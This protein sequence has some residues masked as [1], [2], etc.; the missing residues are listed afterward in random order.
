MADT[1]NQLPID[2]V[3]RPPEQGAVTRSLASIVAAAEA[4]GR[5]FGEA[6]SKG[7]KSGM[8]GSAT[9]GSDSPIVKRV[10]NHVHGAKKAL[11]DASKQIE[12]YYKKF[13]KG[14]DAAIKSLTRPGYNN[15][16]PAWWDKVL[17][18]Q[19]AG[20]KAIEASQ[21]RAEATIGKKAERVVRAATQEGYKNAGPAWWSKVL[22]EQEKAFAKMERLHGQALEMDKKF[23]AARE[24]EAQR[25]AV[26]LKKIQDKEEF[27]NSSAGIYSAAGIKDP[28]QR[29]SEINAVKRAQSL[30]H[31]ELAAGTIG[32]SQYSLGMGEAQKRLNLLEA[33]N[34]RAR[35]SVH[36]FVASI[37]SATFEL[38]GFIYGLTT[39]AAIAG[40][41]ALFGANYLK[42]IEDAKMGMVGILLSMGQVDGKQ[43]SLS[44]AM[45]ISQ[46][47]I[48]DLSAESMKYAVSLEDVTKSFQAMLGPGLAAGM[49]LQQ[50]GKLATIGTL[51]VKSMGLDSRQVVQELR[52][53][54]AG[55]IQAAS[56][57]LATA[58]GL[59]DSDIK[60]AKESSEGLF[61]FLEK[62]LA[63]FQMAAAERQNTLSGSFDMLKLKIQ[64]LFS[65][66]GGFDALKEMI[67]S[68]SDSIG[69][70]DVNGKLTLNPDLVKLMKSYWEDT[71]L[72]AHYLGVAVTTMVSMID[73]A[74]AL[75]KAFIA[76]K[77]AAIILPTLMAM[78]TA[79]T[80]FAP[81]I[82]TATGAMFTFGVA[83]QGVAMR[84]GAMSVA[85]QAGLIGL[86]LYGT[87]SFL[88]HM[89][90]IDDLFS[91]AETRA[92]NFQD[93]IK[94]YDLDQL[95][96]RRMKIQAAKEQIEQDNKN[97]IL[98]RR[99]DIDGTMLF[100]GAALETLRSQEQE[101]DRFIRTATEKKAEGIKVE[102]RMRGA[103]AEKMLA[104]ESAK[105]H[106][107][108]QI[109]D[110]YQKKATESLTYYTTA[111]VQ[112]Q[113][114]FSNAVTDKD[115]EAAQNRIDTI[116]KQYR[117]ITENDKM[118]KDKELK[119][120]QKHNEVKESEAARV[121]DRMRDIIARANAE[122]SATFDPSVDEYTVKYKNY[123]ETV[124]KFL[125]G[126][127]KG[128]QGEQ[129][130][131][132]LD[133]AAA[134]VATAAQKTKEHQDNLRKSFKDTTYEIENNTEKLKEETRMLEQFGLGAKASALAQAEVAI[135]SKK[136]TSVL[137]DEETALRLTMAASHDL[138]SARN[139]LT[140]T[141]LEYAK[142]NADLDAEMSMMFVESEA[143]KVRIAQESALKRIDAERS[144][145]EAARA[146]LI[147][148]DKFDPSKQRDYE[149]A[150]G[151]LQ[152][153]R[154]NIYA[155]GNKK[156]R[157]AELKDWKKT[158]QDIE[159][160]GHDGFMSLFDRGVNGWKTMTTTMKN[161]FKAT[162][163]ESIYKEL[164]KP[165]ILKL[166]ANVAGVMGLGGI[167]GTAN[168]MSGGGAIASQ[169]M[170]LFTAGKTLWD[171]FNT[172]FASF[173]NSV[174]QTVQSGMNFM[175]GSGGFVGQGPME[176]SSFAQ[177]AGTIAPYLASIG[178]GKMVSSVISNGYQVNHGNALNNIGALGGIIGS[179]IT[180]LINRAFGSKVVG[181]GVM[182]SVSGDQFSGNAYTFSRGGW[183]RGDRTNTS[184]LD[185]AV[186]SVFAESIRGMY[187]NFAALGDTIGVGSTLLEDFSYEFRL[188]LADFDDAGKEKA[189]KAALARMS[190]SMAGAFVDSFRTSIDTAQQA[191]SRYY[192][193]TSDG[194]RTFSGGV[195]SQTAVSSPLDPYINDIIRIFDAQRESLAG[196][197]DSE[198]KLAEFTTALFGLADGL[199]DNAGYARIF[200]EA[201][202]FVKL[203]SAAK[204][205]ETVIDA[206]ARLN[207]VFAATSAVAV[208]LDKDVS[209]AFGAIGL[210]STE[211]RERL[212]TLAGGV[213]SLASSMSFFS[214]NFLTEAERL[215]PI[216]DSVV[217]EMTRLGLASVTTHEQFRDVVRGLDL[218]SASGAQLFADLMKVQGAFDT[219]ADAAREAAQRELEL[220]NKR[221]GLEIQIMDLSGDAAGALAAQRALE[222]A[223]MDESL[224]PLQQRIYLL[225]DEAKAAENHKKIIEDRTQILEDAYQRETDALQNTIEKFTNFTKSLRAFRDSLLTGNLSNL[226]PE[227]RY[228]ELKRQFDSTFALARTGNEDALGELEGIS[229]QFLEASR[230][231]FAS[232]QAYSTDFDYVRAALQEAA[233]A[234][235][236]QVDVA[237]AQ[238][239]RLDTLVSGLITLNNSTIS[240]YQ[241]VVNLS[242][243]MTAAGTPA[244]ANPTTG[245]T[246][247]QGVVNSLFNE[248]LGRD[249]RQE[250]LDFYSTALTTN[251]SVEDVRNSLL[252]SREY[253]SN[254]IESLYTDILGRHS[255]PEGLNFWTDALMNGVS[256]DHIREEFLNSPEYLGMNGSHANGLDYVPFD[257]YRAELHRGERV[258]TAAEA[259][260]A[261]ASAA[262]LKLQTEQLQALVRQNAAYSAAV[263]AELQ[264][265]KAELEEIKSKVRLTENM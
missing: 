219:V 96:Y 33:G 27:K 115:K 252:T 142:E 231:Y 121:S 258:Q 249:A 238:L 164:A 23:N 130:K 21:A 81:A 98:P 198:G 103:A 108:E 217:A 17:T 212:I 43:M 28:Q 3:I 206:F 55:G 47:T 1:L 127:L 53:L 135:S 199:A 230:D 93:K 265:V 105:G 149:E 170:S 223:G 254:Q 90:Q 37:A 48:K 30:L 211:A 65:D 94:N 54:V 138:A 233:N 261:D 4:E 155:N 50:V 25:A 151:T 40:A 143:E 100:S 210:A 162:V 15:A 134:D 38:T 106:T 46:Q 185:P 245:L 79:M 120:L 194:A 95:K 41:P 247:V 221:R 181:S 12:E 222:L 259:R 160:I 42:S 192:T 124:Q 5:K 225:Q 158:V 9:D 45:N 184:A 190:D 137:S 6:F 173:G 32:F 244:P 56:S 14:V 168:A 85:S 157:L 141:A 255:R 39:L 7:M 89:A 166:I 163:L 237:Q 112:A 71:K 242:A 62:R 172:G 241:A 152:R 224:R 236:H 204:H 264:A 191:A 216:Q 256:L 64:R 187:A 189:I 88:D 102:S 159:K 75:V 178:I 144:I 214:Q 44:N 70:I 36:R 246:P 82:A 131:A 220:A 125:R 203:E 109:Q 132:M 128:S 153:A 114:D 140:K 136:F 18:K 262:E 243:A 80:A 201:L 146:R 77:A 116:Q 145:A 161:M 260:S 63:G 73:P 179:T 29:V 263:V 8:G 59:K 182:G 174:A 200:G 207:I 66:E 91:R 57:T 129:Q 133:A 97:N 69:K 19:D 169:G 58:L 92:K 104:E 148:E 34:V 228:L 72:L 26:A 257:G 176:L 208:A 229:Q 186:N 232:S 117:Q 11:G 253:R 165:F 235:Q 202:D 20:L 86:A 99:Y 84:I 126:D 35:G 197:A 31:A 24:R 250:G 74:I 171:G 22:A 49:T 196:V 67:K 119:Q 10:H 183:F 226:S 110:K 234:S 251:S 195:V 101:I 205:G 227:T 113:T 52:D 111:I 118:Q 78:G 60:R 239:T 2:V 123:F 209:T 122:I 213:D 177:G 188:A 107:L 154:E 215:A 156:I 83:A 68:I 76:W 87:Y 61:A 150:L 16:G 51:A 147:L 248:V 218:S 139:E 175:N 240:V 13:D 180:G 193:N 167:A